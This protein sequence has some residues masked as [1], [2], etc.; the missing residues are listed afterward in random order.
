[1]SPTW[2]LL[3]STKPRSRNYGLDDPALAER[4]AERGYVVVPFLD[5][6]AVAELR[7]LHRDVGAAPG[8][9][10]TGLFNDTWATDVDW[11]REVSRRLHEHLDAPVA[12]L[13][14]THRPLGFAHITKW[15]GDPGAVVAHRDPTFVDERH[16]R[17][18]MLWIALDD[19]DTDNGALWVIPGSHREA[20][21]I[22]VHQSP[23]NVELSV[24]PGDGGPAVVVP[25]RAGEAVLY[26]H[27]LV[28]MSAP[29]HSDVPRVAVACPLVPRAATPRYAVPVSDSEA[30]VVLIDERFFLEHRLCELDPEAVL[31][32]YEAVATVPTGPG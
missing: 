3:R 14:G 25:L 26:D 20:K 27:A 5:D 4:L 13:V 24:S 9:P 18:L 1:M 11:K 2:P 31:R 6:D 29:N 17:S 7:Q 32:S 22:R 23:A 30:R 10:R 28:H 12:A 16:H 15:P 21:G 8:D 19:T